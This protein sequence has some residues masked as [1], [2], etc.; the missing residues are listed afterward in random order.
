MP[1]G[2]PFAR[3]RSR[4][5]PT[6]GSSFGVW[7]AWASD[8][9]VRWRGSS[10][11]ALTALHGWLFGQR[12]LEHGRLGG[13]RPRSRD[14]PFRSRSR[15][16][17]RPGSRR[18]ARDMPRSAYSPNP[19]SASSRGDHREAVRD[20]GDPAFG[21]S[22][23]PDGAGTG[24]TA[25]ADP[26][27]LSFFCAGTPSQRRDRELLAMLG[28][29][30]GESLDD[31]WYRGRGWPG[32]FTVGPHR[33]R[34]VA[35][36]RGVLGRGP[37]ARRR[38]G[39]ARC[40]PTAWASPPMSS[41]PTSGGW[42]NAGT[43]CSPRGPGRAPSS[44]APARG[45]DAVMAAEEAG[46][47]VLRPIRMS[48]LADVQPLQRK[49]RASLFGRLLGSRLAGVPGPRYRGFRLW[50]FAVAHPRLNLRAA[51]GARDRIRRSTSVI[52]PTSAPGVRTVN[53]SLDDD[54]RM[55][56]DRLAL[57]VVNFAS[58][59]LLADGPRPTATCASL[60]ARGRDR[61]QSEL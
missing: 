47:I 12:A 29:R 25:E 28:V 11:G 39:A 43:R 30:P 56:P 35:E 38:T 6:M 31:L 23:R 48:E 53:A 36:L 16:R 50:A 4:R 55:K 32:R 61:R 15:R 7:E 1:R 57:V 3:A 45:L 13:H 2:R 33:R 51:R 17:P 5:H 27:L 52:G 41:Q 21:A 19:T 46:A 9:A 37:R 54:P 42:T 24:D 20:R 58:S 10:G 59:S 18:P 60:V 26:I 34:C 40:A 22:A 44:P 49:R 8:E 14:A